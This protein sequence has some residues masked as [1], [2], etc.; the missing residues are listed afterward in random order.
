VVEQD[1]LLLQSS[2]NTMCKARRVIYKFSISSIVFP[3]C[4]I[5]DTHNSHRDSIHTHTISTISLL[6]GPRS[7]DTKPLESFQPGRE[8]FRIHL[9]FLSAC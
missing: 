9:T 8:F 1:V 7:F 3:L 2:N 5:V 6:H 4:L